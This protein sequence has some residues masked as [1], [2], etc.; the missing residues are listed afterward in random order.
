MAEVADLFPNGAW[1]VHHHI[2]DPARYAY[3]PTRHLTPPPATIA[4]FEDFKKKLGITNSVLT[5]GLSY[6]SD[7]S[8]LQDFVSELG[9]SNTKA[10]GVID[11]GT[12]TVD[13]LH[14]M[15]HA[16]ICGIRVNLY[17]YKAM[18]DVD[19]QKNALRAHVE[20]IK[21]HC[22]RWSM[23][24]THVHPEFWTELKPF[25]ETEIVP[26]GIRLVTDH[27]ALLKG[28]SMLPCE[29]GDESRVVDVSQQPGFREIIQLM[30]AGYLYI[31][32]SAPYRVSTQAPG[33]DDLKPLVRAF[34]DANPRQVVWGS[35]W[36]HTPQMKVRTQE[37]ALTETPY[38]KVDDLAW[39]RSL[40]SWLSDEEWHALMVANPS[41]LYR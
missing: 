20:A 29:A 17:Q 2:F 41:A 18:H 6:G 26:T 37:E 15:Q 1:D 28:S 12:V 5:H 16:G 9:A 33:F 14:E 23:A 24:F 8:S 39:L 38:L 32:I 30:R 13:E 10:I 11:P 35:D 40:R 36:P 21:D 31:K 19:L 4:Q 7:C 3:S 27:F 34:F 25:I 22:P